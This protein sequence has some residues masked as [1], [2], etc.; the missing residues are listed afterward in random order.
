MRRRR[1][2][3]LA[4]TALI[5]GC[6]GDSGGPDPVG[7]LAPTDE[8]TPEPTPTD[9][10]TA[11]DAPTPEATFEGSEI[12]TGGDGQKWIKAAF[13]NPTDVPHGYFRVDHTVYDGE[14]E[15]VDTRDSTIDIIPA[16]TTWESYPIVLGERREAAETV[17]TAIVTDEVRYPPPV[18]DDVEIVTST[19]HKD[20]RSM[21]E[22]VGEVRNNGPERTVWVIAAIYT[23]DGTLR[24]TVQTNVRELD[25][26]EKRGFRAAIVGQWTPA[27]M[28]SALPTRHGVYA[29]PDRI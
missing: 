22:V 18:A 21:T 26:G 12:I 3:A 6:G 9:T 24:G 10:P 23:D 29:S 20:Y 19:L 14:G 27:G 25:E 11:T 8:S 5:A 2:L 15:V 17:E 16:G 4:G 7:T 28:E 13:S 1:Y